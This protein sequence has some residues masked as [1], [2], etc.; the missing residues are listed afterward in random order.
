MKDPILI[1]GCARSGTSLTAGIINI[2]GAFGGELSGPSRFNRKGMFENRVIRNLIVKPYL[3]R[4]GLDRMGQLPLPDI[5]NL[6]PFSNLKDEVENIIIKQNYKSGPWFYKG[7]KVC[8]LWPL[9]DDAFPN[10]KWVIVRRNSN[11]I[12]NSC[13]RTPFMRAYTEVEGWQIWVDEHLKRFNEMQEADLNIIEVWPEQMIK[14]NN[15]K[16]TKEMIN[17]LGLNWKEKE[18]KEFV[19]PNLWNGGR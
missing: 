11:D 1:T 6:K 15:Y 9:W 12:I 19:S 3:K 4:S 17:S 14:E 8:L 18:V 7:A 16:P 10:A 2:C 5:N 13:L